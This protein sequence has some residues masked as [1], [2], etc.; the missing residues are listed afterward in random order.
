MLGF[1]GLL[2]SPKPIKGVWD[3]QLIRQA[4]GFLLQKAL[5]QFV[6]VTVILRK[7]EGKSYKGFRDEVDFCP[8]IFFSKSKKAMSKALTP[9]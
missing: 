3:S 2:R 5:S 7:K 6:S 9:Y 8:I 1:I 4:P